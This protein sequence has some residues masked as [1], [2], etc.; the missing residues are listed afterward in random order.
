MRISHPIF[1]LRHTPAGSALQRPE[2]IV[3]K[4]LLDEAEVVQ[5]EREM[6]HRHPDHGQAAQGVE[7][8]KAGVA[9]GV[10]P[11]TISGHRNAR[12]AQADELEVG[13]QQHGRGLQRDECMAQ[14]ARR[15][16]PAE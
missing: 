14:A 13:E 11:T 16:R 12:P 7:S 2:R 8:V 3:V 5:V 6:E 4:V 15:E 10:H 9:G 1:S